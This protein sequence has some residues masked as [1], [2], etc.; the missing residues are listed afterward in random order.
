MVVMKQ[1]DEEA[2][3]VGLVIIALFSFFIITVTLN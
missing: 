3:V 1:Q 2:F